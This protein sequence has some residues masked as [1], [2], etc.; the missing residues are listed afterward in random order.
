M[1]AGAAPGGARQEAQRQHRQVLGER[2]GAEHCGGSPHPD[3]VHRPDHGDGAGGDL[4]HLQRIQ[5]HEIPQVLREYGRDGPERGGAYDHEF[6]PAEEKCR[7]WTKA[8]EDVG[9]DAPGARQRC[10][11]L[12]KTQRSAQRDKT[13][14][15][16]TQDDGTRIRQL[17]GHGRGHAKDAA[18]DGDADR[19]CHGVEQADRPRHALAPFV[20]AHGNLSASNSIQ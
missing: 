3:V 2:R 13:A 10:R 15:H 17:P 14:G 16:P 7:Q 8:L 19:D 4:A 20:D 1:R 18:A 11:Q 9:E 12:R 6:R 5:R